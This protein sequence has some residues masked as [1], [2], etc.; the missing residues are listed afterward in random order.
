MPGPGSQRPS[1]AVSAPAGTDQ[2]RSKARKW[3]MRMASNR[4]EAPSTLL[5]H[6]PKPSRFWAAQSYRGL[7]HS[8]P[9]AEK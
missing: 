8:W 2:Y 9:S 1:L 6:Q 4:R 5:I 7:P 3:S